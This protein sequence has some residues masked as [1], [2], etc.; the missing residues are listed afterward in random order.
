V[1]DLNTPPTRAT[2]STAAMAPPMAPPLTSVLL[3]A[4]L[5]QGHKFK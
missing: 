4:L 1:L 2:N 5:V 3:L